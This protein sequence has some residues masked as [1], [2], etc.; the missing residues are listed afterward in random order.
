MEAPSNLIH[1]SASIRYARVWA[2]FSAA[3]GRGETKTLSSYCRLTH[4]SYDG[5]K[6]W[7]RSQG[8][9][10]KSLKRPNSTQETAL[11]ACKPEAG[12]VSFIQFA[13]SAA[14]ASAASMR[15][16]S[17]IFPDGVNLSLQECSAESVADLLAIYRSRY[18]AAGGR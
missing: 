10:V 7:I 8:L 9:S 15:G 3:V 16:I 5:I 14:P 17:I 1:E 11:A 6:H 2:D 12:P 13:P 4:T 18:G